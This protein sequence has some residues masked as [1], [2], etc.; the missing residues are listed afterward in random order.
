MQ[1]C[2]LLRCAYRNVRAL[3]ASR[4]RISKSN[5]YKEKLKVDTACYETY[6]IFRIINDIAHHMYIAMIPSLQ[7]W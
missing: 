2:L 1:A 4:G 5:A 3:V 7:E 6:I